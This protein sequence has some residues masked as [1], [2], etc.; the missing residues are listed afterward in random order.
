MLT[1]LKYCLFFI[2]ISSF[3]FANDNSIDSILYIKEPYFINFNS[4]I[5]FSFQNIESITLSN[6]NTEFS[7]ING[8][9]FGFNSYFGINYYLSPKIVCRIDID[10]IFSSSEFRNKNIYPIRSKDLTDTNNVQ[11]DNVLNN[12]QNY[13]FFLPKIS[14]NFLK[15]SKNLDFNFN[16]GIGIA[17]N[18]NNNYELKYEI[19]SPEYVHFISSNSKEK[20]ISKDIIQNKNKIN[21]PLNASLSANLNLNK[22]LTLTSEIGYSKFLINITKDNNWQQNALYFNLG[23]N[24]YFYTKKIITHKN[25]IEINIDT[26]PQK[27]ELVVQ[28]LKDSSKF[29]LYKGE[30]I[31]AT[32]PMVNSVFFPTNSSKIPEYYITNDKNLPNIFEY[33]FIE[34]RRYLFL[35]I[36]E[37]LDENP[38]AKITISGYTSGEKNEKNNFDLARQRAENVKKIFID[39]GIDSNRIKVQYAVL[40]P[41]PSNMDFKEGILENQRVDILLENAAYQK[42]VNLLDYIKIQGNLKIAIHLSNISKPLEL[43]TNVSDEVKIVYKAGIYEIPFNLKI[44]KNSYRIIA[45]VKNK[46]IFAK[47]SIQINTSSIFQT[48]SEISFDSFQAIMLFEYGS[49]KLSKKNQALIDQLIEFLKDGDRIIIQGSADALGQELRNK[50]LTYQ[51]AKNAMDYIKEHTSKN[52]KIEISDNYEKFSEETSEG[53]FLN[54]AIKIIV[55]RNGS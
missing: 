28:I 24:Y 10:Y 42:F 55:V 8:T 54:R 27:P 33:D 30:E 48:N 15:P 20:L 19:V 36:K 3:I 29:D 51:R 25:N 40:P 7:N 11:I 9:G 49:D 46:D 13:I 22:N 17:Y 26:L 6:F 1:K 53:R 44:N 16:I 14:Y 12:S 38:D 18:L 4:G 37:I 47:D 31:I 45:T 43:R 34:L 52:I 23:L 41:N 50:E 2:L 21:I 39:F 32:P 5:N 35:R